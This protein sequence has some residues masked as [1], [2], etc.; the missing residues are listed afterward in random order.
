MHVEPGGPAVS[1]RYGVILAGGASRRMPT[2]KASALLG[3]T[4]LLDR[5]AAT[6][7]AA[8]LEPVVSTRADAV[9]PRVDVPVWPEPHP[10][11]PPH[12]LHGIAAALASAGE[13]IVVLPVDLP[14]LPPPA[15]AA[16]AAGP[17]DAVLASA[18][19][20]AALVA[21]LDPT[22]APM[23]REAGTSG[24]PALATLVALGAVL[25]DLV[26]AAPGAPP[27]A[28]LNVN[29]EVALA[30]AETLLVRG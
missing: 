7:R 23:L 15:L 21:R 9:L 5:A 22:L 12:P 20:P 1:V 25:L 28:L 30:E 19:R 11:G 10:S 6:V 4:T 18:G 26:E 29:D 27:H 13:P 24:A 8:G 2:G 14:F 16:L 17:G 3:G